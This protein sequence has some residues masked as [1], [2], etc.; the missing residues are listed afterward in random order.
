MTKTPRKGGEL[1]ELA[2]E[3]RRWKKHHGTARAGLGTHRSERGWC[4]DVKS[5]RLWQLCLPLQALPVALPG[6]F[7]QVRDPSEQQFESC[8]QG[9]TTQ[10]SNPE[11]PFSSQDRHRIP[12]APALLCPPLAAAAMAECTHGAGA[13]FESQK[14]TPEPRAALPQPLTD[15]HQHPT[16]CRASLQGWE[17]G[18]GSPTQRLCR[19]HTAPTLWESSSPAVTCFP[20]TVSSHLVTSKFIEIFKSQGHSCV[21]IKSL[22]S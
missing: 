8:G 14:P 19:A 9:T 20:C 18:M 16:A 7:T 11:L 10:L 21:Q 22:R 15:F 2:R 5:P 12:A 1:Q 4:Q 3:G 17:A 6:T 13:V